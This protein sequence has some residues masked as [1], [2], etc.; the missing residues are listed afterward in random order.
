MA[1][2]RV[3]GHS[4]VNTWVVS[5]MSTIESLC[6]AAFVCVAA[7]ALTACE[8]SVAGSCTSAQDAAVK[9]SVLSDD[10][11]AAEAAGNL[12]AY[13]LGEVGAKI[14]DAGSRFGAKGNHQSYCLAIEKI[15]SEAG[16]R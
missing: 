8:R 15:R 10:L 14:L 4:S 7:I 3:F 9:V 6:K 12:D 11:L 5:R 16:L 2:Q 13:R 1:F